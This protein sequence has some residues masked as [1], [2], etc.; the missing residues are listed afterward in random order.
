[1]LA[2][3]GRAARRRT[4]RAKMMM[5]VFIVSSPI[6]LLPVVRARCRVES[7][8]GVLEYSPLA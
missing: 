6:V 8:W 5:S 2:V 7:K 1:M 4:A 3:A